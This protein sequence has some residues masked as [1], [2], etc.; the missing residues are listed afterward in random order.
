MRLHTLISAAVVGAFLFFAAAGSPPSVAA[1]HRNSS[2]KT[3]PKVATCPSSSVAAS[4]DF[5]QFGGTSS[6]L[7]GAVVFHNTSTTGCSFRGVPLVE[8]MSDSGQVIST[9]EAPNFAEHLPTAL[10]Q[11][12]NAAHGAQAGSSITFSSWTCTMQSFSL[13]VRFPGWAD[14]IPATAGSP[15]GSCP[16][17]REVDETVF[18]G[19]VVTLGG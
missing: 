6:S 1:A 19:P 2:A 14:S 10:L 4:V 8:V 15:S 9:Y 12:G 3:I 17:S 16:P 5:T 11:A 13:T 7:A 18:V